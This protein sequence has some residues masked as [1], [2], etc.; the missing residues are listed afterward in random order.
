MLVRR[1]KK[2]LPLLQTNSLVFAEIKLMKTMWRIPKQLRLH[3]NQLWLP[4]ISNITNNY[5]TLSRLKFKTAKYS[6]QQHF[7]QGLRSWCLSEWWRRT[8]KLSSS[9]EVIVMQSLKG[10]RIISEKYP[11]LNILLSM[12]TR[13]SFIAAKETKTHAVS[14]CWCP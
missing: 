13:H 12:E 1:N 11:T 4:R 6:V 9:M 8:I 14:P 3:P 2:T 7:F 10:L 5:W